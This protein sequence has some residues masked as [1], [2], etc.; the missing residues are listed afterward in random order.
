MRQAAVLLSLFFSIFSADSVALIFEPV[1]PPGV[2]S[3]WLVPMNSDSGFVY[4]DSENGLFRSDDSGSTWTALGQ[5][6][7]GDVVYFLSH[8]GGTVLATTNAGLYR[9]GGAGD[10]QLIFDNNGASDFDDSLTQAAINPTGE[11]DLFVFRRHGQSFASS[12]GGASWSEFASYDS[13]QGTTF[14]DSAQKLIL[15]DLSSLTAFDLATGTWSTLGLPDGLGGFYAPGL[16]SESNL[17]GRIF[18]HSPGIYYS[19]DLGQSWVAAPYPEPR[20]GEGGVTGLHFSGAFRQM[21]VADVSSR[22]DIGLPSAASRGFAG[23]GHFL[24]TNDGANWLHLGSASRYHFAG[25]DLFSSKNGSHVAVARGVFGASSAV[26]AL[27]LPGILM[28]LFLMAVVAGGAF[29]QM[30]R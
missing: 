5:I 19:D 3:S 2:S 24:S 6:N 21:S 18:I 12:D 9:Y 17:P 16:S 15:M 25:H 13:F 22:T 7:G 30:E 27:S 10:W 14:L 4:A 8:I 11:Q 23:I 20:Y 26:P 28:L 29:T 1:P